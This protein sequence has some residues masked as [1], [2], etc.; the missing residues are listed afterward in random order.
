MD[1]NA[2]IGTGMVLLLGGVMLYALKTGRVPLAR[3]HIQRD[4][5]PKLYWMAVLLC[6]FLLVLGV[7]VALTP[8]RRDEIAGRPAPNRAAASADVRQNGKYVAAE[9][10]Q[11]EHEAAASTQ[12][13]DV[14]SRYAEMAGLWS[15]DANCAPGSGSALRISADGLDFGHSHFHVESVELE[16]DDLVLQGHYVSHRGIKNDSL[17]ITVIQRDPP[18]FKMFGTIYF[19]CQ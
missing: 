8:N 18:K 10:V 12:R 4:T 14:D 19:R 3:S 2:L 11:N 6:A 17:T 15:D 13:G 16:G 9:K 1:D 7:K 5:V